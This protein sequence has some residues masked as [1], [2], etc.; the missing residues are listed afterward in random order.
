MD[1]SGADR[2]PDSFAELTMPFFGQS[3]ARLGSNPNARR[4]LIMS[5][6]IIH[7]HSHDGIDRQG[8]LK[9]MAWTGTGVSC[10]LKGGA[11]KSCSLSQLVHDA[12]SIKGDP[13][14]GRIDDNHL[15]SNTLTDAAVI[16]SLLSWITQEQTIRDQVTLKATKPGAYRVT[17]NIQ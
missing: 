14:L 3:G 13:G 12:R 1:V 2:Q 11:L 15:G 4:G 7:D 6:H 16:A 17:R 8:F 10:V 5:D 9:F